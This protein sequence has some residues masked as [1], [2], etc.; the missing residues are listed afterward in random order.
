MIWALMKE[1]GRWEETDLQTLGHLRHVNFREEAHV[2]TLLDSSAGRVRPVHWN[3]RMAGF[4][5]F[6]C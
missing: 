3:I 6:N 5:G 2:V 1:Y 4:G